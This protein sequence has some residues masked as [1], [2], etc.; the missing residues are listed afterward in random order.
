MSSIIESCGNEGVKAAA[1]ITAGFVRLGLAWGAI[2]R[3]RTSLQIRV[4][5]QRRLCQDTNP[6]LSTPEPAVE[7]FFYFSAY[8]QTSNC[9]VKWQ[10]RFCIISNRT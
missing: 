7:G 1:M 8:Y 2:A 5:G 6:S 3:Y 9:C 4:I 10:G